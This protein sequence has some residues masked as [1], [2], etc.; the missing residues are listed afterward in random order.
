M[1]W[2]E[3]HPEARLAGQLG[4]ARRHLRAAF[5]SLVLIVD[6]RHPSDEAVELFD[7]TLVEA[8]TTSLVWHA[9]DPGDPRRQEWREMLMRLYRE[10]MT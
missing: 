9:V 5:R 7:R 10:T 3:N 6:K 2:L 8:V 4:E 1:R